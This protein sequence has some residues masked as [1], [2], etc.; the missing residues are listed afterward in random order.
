MRVLRLAVPT[1]LAAAAVA[2]LAVRALA[3]V[4]LDEPWTP[5]RAVAAAVVALGLVVAL[6]LTLALLLGLAAAIARS[7]GRT[8]RSG[9]SWARRVAP[10][11][12][13]GALAA[14]LGATVAGPAAHAT[15][16]DPYPDLG[17]RVT[18]TAAAAP[19]D[20]TTTATPTTAPP[21]PAATV[22]VRAGDSLWRIAARH[23]PAEADDAA[24]A[25]AWPVWYEL[26]RDVVGADP[27]L[28]HPG[29]VL[30]VPAAGDLP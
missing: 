5:D 19:S 9:E 26:N 15:E 16:P 1:L 3:L 7:A 4:R 20:A 29:Q 24:I 12:A 2:A 25:A 28:V 30:V 22:T 27:D 21:T 18:S 6:R 13:R 17:W 23:L 10:A 8:W 11:F 14:V